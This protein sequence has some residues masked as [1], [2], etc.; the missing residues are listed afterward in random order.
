MSAS[1]AQAHADVRTA[2]RREVEVLARDYPLNG[3][4][5]W[6]RG[7]HTHQGKVIN[8]GQL[9]PHLWAINVNTGKEVKVSSF[10]II[11]AMK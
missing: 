10:D 1:L 6:K 5:Y 7:R 4:V 3:D 9:S 2:Q 8:H 11:E